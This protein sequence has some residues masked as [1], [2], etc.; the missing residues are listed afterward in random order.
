MKQTTWAAWVSELRAGDRIFVPGGPGEPTGLPGALAAGTAAAA[1]FVQFPLPGMN[2]FDYSL[3]G[4]GARQETFFLTPA[5]REGFQAGRV[6]FH[7]LHMRR[8]F[9][10]LAK[11]PAFDWVVLM[12]RRDEEGQWRHG[13]NVDFL[14]AVLPQ[15][16]AVLVQENPGL[17]L[18]PGAPRLDPAQITAVIVDDTALPE[19]AVPALDVAS[20]AIG[21]LVAARVP[22]GAC[23]QTGIGQIPAAVL[24]A[25][26]GHRDLGFHGGLVDAGVLALIEAGVLTG[27]RKRRDRGVHVTA[28][29]LGDRTFYNALE[30]VPELRFC[31]AHI[32]HESTIIAGL[33]HFVS[34]NS[35]VEVDLFGQVNAETVGGR[36]ISGPGG[37]VDFMRAAA[38]APEG[39]SIVA[40]TATAKGGALSRIVPTLAAGT[41][42]TGLRTDSDVIVTEFGVAEL[43]GKSLEA[44]AEALIAV[45]AP[46]H[47]E[48]LTAAWASLRARI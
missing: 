46:E 26:R 33:D 14:P 19:L 15:A 28:M 20:E 34:I 3:A 9:D 17:P 39:Q 2:R 27:A 30:G 22:D 1:S 38:G 23:L 10:A 43:K 40:L 13:L 4:P 36:Q 7:P 29:A 21:S 8:T 35:A 41:P 37:A 47:R 12:A 11:G 24:H 18:L 6:A 25:L 45:A 16:R 32:T 5:L 48:D 44:R 42:A 31:G